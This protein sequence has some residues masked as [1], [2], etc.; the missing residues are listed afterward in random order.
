MP[1]YK[2]LL[3]FI[4]SE[5]FINQNINPIN[6]FVSFISTKEFFSIVNR[7]IIE[8]YK[9]NRYDISID[10]IEFKIW[11][12]WETW[13]IKAK[14]IDLYFWY[15]TSS[16]L[17]WYRFFNI[18]NLSN[19]IALV[20]SIYTKKI[21]ENKEN[22][23]FLHFIY[24][25]YLL[26]FMFASKI[27]VF[28]YKD[29]NENFK[30]F[31]EVFFNFYNFI[32]KQF[33]K[34]HS[35]K[36]WED[37]KKKL[38]KEVDVFFMLFSFYKKMNTFL[39]IW[40]KNEDYIQYTNRLLHDEKKWNK[41]WAIIQD[42]IE[43]Y[44]TQAKKTNFSVTEK[45]IMNIILPTDILLKYIFAEHNVYWIVKHIVEKIY[46]KEQLTKYI[47]SFRKWDWEL[48]NFL[49]YIS[50]YR[51]F[52]KNFFKNVKKY[53]SIIFNKEVIED[54][55]EEDIEEFLS[56]IWNW[57]IENIKVPE[58]IKKESKFME[59]M[60]NFYVNFIWWLRIWRWNNLSIIFEKWEFINKFLNKIEW[61]KIYN[62]PEFFAKNYSYFADLT[63][64]YTKN[65]FYYQFTSDKIKNWKNKITLPTFNIKSEYYWVNKYLIEFFKKDAITVLLQDLN[66]K[67]LKL[68]IKNN[69]LI[70]NFKKNYS[71]KVSKIIA[72]NDKSFLK[73]IYKKTD[74]ILWGNWK[75]NELIAITFQNTN[76]VTYLKDNLYCLDYRIFDYFT[77]R[78]IK[79]MLTNLKKTL[80]NTEIL[81]LYAIIRE[82]LF[83]F[84][85][86][87]VYFIESKTKQTHIKIF[88]QQYIEW[89]L[90]LREKE[91]IIEINKIIHS[92]KNEF[93]EI[94]K[95]WLHI[96]DNRQFLQIIK[97]KRQNSTKNK[98]EI[99]ISK[100]MVW[101]DIIWFKGFL[102]NIT[103][104]NKRYLIPKDI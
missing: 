43:E 83:W 62:D 40:E 47:K 12:W 67:D 76:S 15:C 28:P 78:F 75:L 85:L 24:S 56:S 27:K 4:F 66:L 14:D 79:K 101:D 45:S 34:N 103:Y 104:Y 49:E 9:L 86:F 60:L 25:I 52:K 44:P 100:N 23:Y 70:I 71:E 16:N 63:K 19:F 50:D 99:D 82:T 87:L 20:S 29:K 65:A 13:D 46:N 53:M 64:N 91:D 73:K 5:E 88:F 35:K 22:F 48:Q 59:Q 89:I 6:M 95:I 26:S 102:K 98:T 74:T 90:N 30:R 31:I 68:Y 36:I 61:Q 7:K 51:F 77:D 11:F 58:K 39:N 38:I 92:I 3:M 1:L 18:A 57:D 97:N 33:W 21:F 96:D 54:D 72:L 32:N 42:Y 17:N 41:Y 55:S 84:I 80:N 93:K 37:I 8:N 94:I 10:P 69:E 81:V 2:R